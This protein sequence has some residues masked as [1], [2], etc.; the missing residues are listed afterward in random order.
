M[1]AMRARAEIAFPSSRGRQR[2]RGQQRT[3]AARPRRLTR[4]LGGGSASHAA[5][6]VSTAGRMPL[7]QARQ[8]LNLEPRGVL[9]RDDIM[10]SFTKYYEANDADRCVLRGARA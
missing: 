2:V 4:R 7:D 10:R 5:R 3:R 6:S 1:R 8:I 9:A